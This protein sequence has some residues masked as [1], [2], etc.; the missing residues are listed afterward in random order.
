M[1]TPF[2][3]LWIKRS[4]TRAFPDAVSKRRSIMGGK[5]QQLAQPSG[6]RLDSCDCGNAGNE[7]VGAAANVPRQP[8]SE[9]TPFIMSTEP[10]RTREIVIE[11]IQSGLND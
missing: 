4:A 1:T 3:R 8:G 5:A 10:R 2:I 9:K 6:L 11:A 7:W